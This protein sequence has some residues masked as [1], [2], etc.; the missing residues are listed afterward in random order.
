MESKKAQT[1]TL[2]ALA[3]P[4]LIEIMMLRL[5]GIADTFMLS[6]YSDNAVAAVGFSDQILAMTIMLCSMVTIGTT[7]LVSR[8]VGAKDK[9]STSE[10][11]RVSISLNFLFGL[12]ISLILIIFSP[13]ILQLMGLPAEL[14]KDATIYMFIIGG[15]TF[16][17]SLMLTV[18]A[19]MKGHGLTKQVMYVMTGVNIL[20]IIGN[21]LFIFGPFGIPVLGVKGVAIA[22]VASRFIGMIILFV[23]LKKRIGESIP[24][25][26]LFRFPKQHVKNLLKI[27]IPSS[28][29]SIA[30]NLQMVVIT[31]FIAMIGT[32]A[33]TTNVYTT[34]LRAFITMFS[35][36]LGQGTLILISRKIGEK[37]MDEAFKQSMHIYKIAA[38][39][40][41]FVAGLF[42]IF[43]KP[44]LKIFT[45]SSDIIVLG[46][47][48][49]LLTLL[50]EPGRAFNLI[51]NNSLKAAG[52]VNFPVF[53]A[54]LGMWL[55]SVPI[56]Y[57]LGIHFGL[58]LI[59]IWI[60]FVVDEWVRGIILM[61][62][63]RSRIWEDKE[64][65]L[66]ASKA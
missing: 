10:I 59:G 55:I 20:N 31:I 23:I 22:T 37:R 63:W 25:T 57:I 40:A 29:D 34:N 39:V 5:M 44:L 33:L 1:L 65:E 45:N 26:K 58:G 11:T 56:A 51:F 52:D 35:G 64:K 3:W 16:I 14:M 60:G 21:Y 30:W 9:L 6:H 32:T 54:I 66:E 47:S 49:I 27:G 38:L 13:T 17:Q 7:I 41:L 2:F 53:I 8:Y 61:R 48:I 62:R 28:V 12:I 42:F 50:L 18:S 19:V 43:S 36:A 46:S 15:F 4:I 24:L